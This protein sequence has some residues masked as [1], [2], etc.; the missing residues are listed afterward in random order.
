MIGGIYGDITGKPGEITHFTVWK[1]CP[2]KDR[3]KWQIGE[4]AKQALLAA[5]KQPSEKVLLEAWQTHAPEY[6]PEF[7]RRM[8]ESGHAFTDDTVMT[9]AT[10]DAL[11]KNTED[12]NFMASYLDWGRKYLKVG[13]GGKFSEWL[14]SPNPQPYG[15]HGNGAAM[16]IGPIG[17]LKYR[18][19]EDWRKMIVASCAP[20][21]NHPEAIRGAMAVADCIRRSS[22]YSDEQLDK[23]ELRK[24]IENKYFYD[25]GR[26]YFDIKKDYRFYVEAQKSVP[27]AIIAFL[28][29]NSVQS[30][31]DY[32]IALGGDSDTQAMMA[33]SMAQ[34]YDKEVPKYMIEKVE[35]SLP[36]EMLNIIRSFES[37]F[38]IEYEIV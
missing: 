32:A 13:F 17:Y 12:P 7:E 5:T 24:M 30:S 14:Q 6:L 9:I 15:S 23:K 19:E 28:A 25:L 26:D 10:M 8:N 18:R 33:G 37:K 11:L 22:W 3:S 21:H 38:D 36:V 34:A 2:G 1:L 16:R 20:S 29:S 35:S 27:E 4:V 31:I